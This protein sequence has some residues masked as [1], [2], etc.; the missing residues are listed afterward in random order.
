VA[1][2]DAMNLPEHVSCVWPCDRHSHDSRR[3]KR[4]IDEIKQK[5]V[6]DDTGNRHDTT[7]GIATTALGLF[8]QGIELLTSPE[9]SCKD[10]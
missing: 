4:A 6:A 2:K 10:E 9:L 3:P 7:I 5:H 8:D 1:K